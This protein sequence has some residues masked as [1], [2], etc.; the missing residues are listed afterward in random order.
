MKNRHLSILTIVLLL[1]SNTANAQHVA[2]K[3]IKS[4]ADTCDY[5]NSK[6]GYDL[7]E[8]IL[9]NLIYPEPA[10]EGGV[11]GK[12]KV[13]FRVDASGNIS[14][15]RVIR[16]IGS[17]CDEEARRVIRAMPTW[18]PAYCKNKA[19]PSV[20]MIPVNFKIG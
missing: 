15:V 14:R 18:L 9:K 16:G 3:H 5:I 17:G 7:K 12:V 1:A 4:V 13:E 11:Q 20:Q 2:K 6:P 8:Y 10:R 19:V